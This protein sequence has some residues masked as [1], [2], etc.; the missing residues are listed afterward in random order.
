MY[1]GRFADEETGLYYYRARSYSPITGRFLQRD[2]FGYLDGTSL[3]EYARSSPSLYRDPSG[4]TAIPTGDGE[5]EIPAGVLAVQFALNSL[6]ELDGNDFTGDRY[7]HV[8]SIMSVWYEFDIEDDLGPTGKTRNHKRKKTGT[9]VR[10]T[11]EREIR[12]IISVWKVTTTTNDV[13]GPFGAGTG[14]DIA[15]TAARSIMM[16]GVW[17]RGRGPQTAGVTTTRTDQL[18][19][20][21]PAS[22]WEGMYESYI[23]DD[24]DV[25][26]KENEKPEP[27][28]RRPVIGEGFSLTDPTPASPT[29]PKPPAL[30]P[31]VN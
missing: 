29:N 10:H 21:G 6:I 14:T 28:L 30:P 20:W 27:L 23:V 26:V 8:R 16:Y 5:W 25:C 17:I 4:T 15:H 31:P 2:P 19:Y 1:T 24:K 11:W 22:Y 12:F 9:L 13:P 18:I 3:Y 7:R